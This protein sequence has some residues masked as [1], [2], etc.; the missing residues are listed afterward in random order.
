MRLNDQQM[1]FGLRLLG[2]ILVVISLLIVGILCIVRPQVFLGWAK[3]AHPRIQ[4]DDEAPLLVVVRLI[5]TGGLIMAAYVAMLV[6][7][8]F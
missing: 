8:A 3:Q 5:G 1:R 7:R 4:V 2:P 6:A